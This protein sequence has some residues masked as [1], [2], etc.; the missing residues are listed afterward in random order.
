MDSDYG[1]LDIPFE[2]AFWVLGTV[3]SRPE[4]GRCVI[5]CGHKSMT[6]DHGYP[7]ARDVVGAKVVA[8]NDEHATVS[9]PPDCRLSVGTRVYF[10][11]SHVDPTTNLHDVFY[12]FDGDRVVGVWPIAARGY[13]EPRD[14]ATSRV[15][16]AR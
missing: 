13:P 10:Q 11:P 5:D 2:Q 8:L 14:V 4:S 15:E 16:R 1:R 6:K 7:V 3:V 9:V 12:V